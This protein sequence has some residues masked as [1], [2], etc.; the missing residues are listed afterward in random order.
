MG[1]Q[2]INTEEWGIEEKVFKPV[3]ARL[4]RQ[5]PKTK[6]PLNV[7]FVDDA[8]IHRLNKTY[9]HKDQPTDVL[10]FSFIGDKDPNPDS[11]LGEIYI[12][13]P[14]AKK[15][16]PH[17]GNTLEKELQKLLVHGTLHVFGYDHEKESDYKKM[18]AMEN[19]ILGF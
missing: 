11:T 18:S 10:S 5:L 6:G 1:I 9:R 7:I 12:S 13:V 3:V 8:E 17:Y 16:A 15:Q 2:F 14:T 4:K 19:K